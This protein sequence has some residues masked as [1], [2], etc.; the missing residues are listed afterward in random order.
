MSTNPAEALAPR[1]RVIHVGE[2]ANTAAQLVQ[3]ARRR[4]LPW[5]HLPLADPRLTWPGPT[6]AVQRAARGAAW[7]VRL[8]RAAARHDV[9]HLH[10]AS[11]YGHSRYVVR[12]F[13][14][15]CHGTDVRT[16]QYEPRLGPVV[17]A[18]L[19]SAERVLY[20]TPDLAEHV[21]PRRPDATYFPV[22]IDVS[23]LRAWSPPERP[24]VAFASR[25]EAVKGLDRQLEVAGA[26]RSALGDRVD[27][28]GLDWGP[29]ADEAR[30]CGVRLVPRLDHAGYLGWLAGSTAVVG[31]A[32]GILS[33]SE[34][35]ALGSGAPLLVPV[36]LPLYADDPPPVLG[37]DTDSVV[38]AV[39]DL[40]GGARHAAAPGRDWVARVHGS[41]HAVD[42]LC[43]LYTD[44]VTTRA[45]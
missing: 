2:A 31:Q 43:A 16:A 25:W 19:D 20:A 5:D 33:A 44:V 9:V 30:A 4:G 40:V 36:P 14:L 41:V 27:L 39:Q 45:T 34:L 10:S 15:H 35:E 32:S 12:R 7:L 26:L 18:A 21:L 28:V 24:R 11:T 22:P 13:V 3:E 1:P 38:E 8:Q 37:A 23:R 17:R 42:A 6:A 29:A